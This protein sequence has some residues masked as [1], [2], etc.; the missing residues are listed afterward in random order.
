MNSR[1]LTGT[2]G[3][4]AVL[5]YKMSRVPSL[6]CLCCSITPRY[7]GLVCIIESVILTVHVNAPVLCN[8]VTKN[9]RRG[10]DTRGNKQG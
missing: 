8:Y 4:Q 6:F 7:S 9:E 3:G 5:L 2:H 10:G 1:K